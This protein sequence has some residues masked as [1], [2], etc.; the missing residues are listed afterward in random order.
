MGISEIIVDR[1]KLHIDGRQISYLFCEKKGSDKLIIT[2]PGFTEVGEFK[3]RYV[4]T[5]K[6]INAH[7]LFILDNFGHRGCY[8]IGENR[9]LS[10]ETAV[11]SLINKLLNEYNINPKNVILNGSSKGGWISL[12]YGIKYGF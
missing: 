8:L 4:R 6:D 9:D 12:Y 10:V 11:M 7:R 5:L 1:E 2:F 3:Y